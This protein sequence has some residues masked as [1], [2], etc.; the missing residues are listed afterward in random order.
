MVLGLDACTLRPLCF[1]SKNCR[2][3]FPFPAIITITI[4]TING[5]QL[6][7]GRPLAIIAAVAVSFPFH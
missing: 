3:L 4:I 5:L 6:F 2:L 7:N 1:L